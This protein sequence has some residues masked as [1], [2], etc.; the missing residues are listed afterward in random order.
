ALLLCGGSYLYR[1]GGFSWAQFQALV[2]VLLLGGGLL[3]VSNL[4]LRPARKECWSV[5][6]YLVVGLVALLGKTM[7]MW[8]QPALLITLVVLQTG[9]V[10]YLWRTR[11]LA[12]VH[13]L[14]VRPH[15]AARKQP[16][17]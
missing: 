9:L 13:S 4:Q 7:G 16:A 8:S 17:E 14:P 6:P 10:G 12:H 3:L 5:L 1:T 2:L 15:R 11:F